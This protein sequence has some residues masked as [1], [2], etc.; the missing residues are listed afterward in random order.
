MTNPTLSAKELTT[1]QVIAARKRARKKAENS[2]GTPTRWVGGRLYYVHEPDHGQ[3]TQVPD[4]PE[5]PKPGKRPGGVE[6][7]FPRAGTRS[8]S[9]SYVTSQPSRSNFW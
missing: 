6:Q 7:A 5:L 9:S 3:W 4:V 2:G 8:R 1:A